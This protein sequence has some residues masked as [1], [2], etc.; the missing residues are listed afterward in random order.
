MTPE[1]E[2][3]ITLA[4]IGHMARH[5]SILPTRNSYGAAAGLGFAIV[6]ERY[7]DRRI[8]LDKVEC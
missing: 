3:T 8:A 1:M 7:L 4:I 2:M 5:Y 6:V